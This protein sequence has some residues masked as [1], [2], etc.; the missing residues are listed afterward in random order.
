MTIIK[1]F[2]TIL[3]YLI[4]GLLA[5][6]SYINARKTLFSPIKTEV[7]KAQ[8]KEFDLITDKFRNIGSY[9]ICKFFDE[10]KILYNNSCILIIDYIK[11][12]FGKNISLADFSQEDLYGA[13]VSSDDLKGRIQ[14]INLTDTENSN[15][16]VF[17]EED[18]LGKLSVCE[19]Y[20][21]KDFYEQIES[22]KRLGKSPV[23][24]EKIFEQIK[25]LI[26]AEYDNLYKMMEVLSDFK[27]KLPEIINKEEEISNINFM[28]LWNSYNDKKFDVYRKVETINES[29]KKY[30]KV[31]NIVK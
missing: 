28:G 7:F 30:L 4:T 23:L 5:V 29:I 8:L 20:I 16:T 11:I 22:I 10:E 9:N 2:V 19:I 21:T 3:F 13:V 18:S 24:P 14:K 1:D 6:L 25:S 31:E 26:N 15:N 27:N 12:K 17:K